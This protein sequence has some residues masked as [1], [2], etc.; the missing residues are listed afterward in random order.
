MCPSTP[1]CVA[2]VPQGLPGQAEHCLGRAL[3]GCPQLRGLSWRV[4]C[5]CDCDGIC[6][7]MLRLKE[8]LAQLHSADVE[9]GFVERGFMRHPPRVP[10]CWP[11]RLWQ[12]SVLWAGS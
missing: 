5:L 10:M 7:W 12:G 6:V 11:E 8:G 3:R 1:P 2:L 9:G 4:L